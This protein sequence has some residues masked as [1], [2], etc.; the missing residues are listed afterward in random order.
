MTLKLK[1][2]DI[3]VAIPILQNKGNYRLWREN[4]LLYAGTVQLDRYVK[5]RFQDPVKML[6][7][8]VPSQEEDAFIIMKVQEN[9]L[10]I[11]NGLVQK[12]QTRNYV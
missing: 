11:T 1:T 3:S 9:G 12:L 5:F 7:G 2:N 4:F 10:A 6:G 8:A